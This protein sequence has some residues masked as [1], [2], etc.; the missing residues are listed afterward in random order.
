MFCNIFQFGHGAAPGRPPAPHF[1]VGAPP[2]VFQGAPA[3]GI[4]MT[5][6]AQAQAQAQVQAHY[7][8]QMQQLQAGHFLQQQP[9]GGFPPQFFPTQMPA[10]N[11]PQL[12]HLQQQ[13]QQQ[14]PQQQQQLQQQQ[15][16]Q[17]PQQ[18]PPAGQAPANLQRPLPTP[19]PP[20]QPQPQLTMPPHAM[21]NPSG[22]PMLGVPNMTGLIYPQQVPAAPLTAPRPQQPKVRAHALVIIDPTTNCPI[23]VTSD[24]SARSKAP[25][26]SLAQQEQSVVPE[27]T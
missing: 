14:Q 22:N 16:Q 6:H 15:Q 7:F 17:L 19:T 8:Q 25:T 24:Q 13:Q 23:D 18:Q 27:V 21:V 2:N 20:T 10:P 11:P 5:A 26:P 9:G 3:A 12:I 4:P 1:G